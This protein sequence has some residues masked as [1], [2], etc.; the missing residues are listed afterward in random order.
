MKISDTDKLAEEYKAGATLKELAE[1]NNCSI[2]TVSRVLHKQGVQ[3]RPKGRKPK[4]KKIVT[5]QEAIATVN[6]VTSEDFKD[7]SETLTKSE[8]SFRVVRPQ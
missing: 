1:K 7:L 3:T 6:K 4:E 8:D 5:A 2:P